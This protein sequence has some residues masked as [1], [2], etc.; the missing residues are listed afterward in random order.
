MDSEVC[1]KTTSLP[2]ALL[3][4]VLL[5]CFDIRLQHRV[6]TGLAVCN[7]RK[8]STNGISY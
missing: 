2:H 1:N 5:F 6:N 3:A 7:P 4:V 8:P